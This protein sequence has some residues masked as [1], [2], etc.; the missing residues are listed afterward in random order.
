[1][2]IDIIKV[3]LLLKCKEIWE[4]IAKYIL[5]ALFYLF[6]TLVAIGVLGF[7]FYINENLTLIL[8]GP[9]QISDYFYDLHNGNEIQKTIIDHSEI[10]KQTTIWKKIAL[11][12]FISVFNLAVAIFSW[13]SLFIAICVCLMVLWWLFF[14]I[15]KT[16]INWLRDNWRQAKRIV[17]NKGK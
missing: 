15:P 16:I 5:T 7:L 14:Y 8:H 9:I 17:N 3:F 1:M 6:V 2:L 4:F 10:L 11:H 13:G 12:I